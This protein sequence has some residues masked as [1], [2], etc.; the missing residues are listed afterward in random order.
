MGVL[1]VKVDGNW[2]DIPSIGPT[3]PAGLAGATG[4]Q[5]AQG[6][7]G[8]PGPD[9]TPVAHAYATV[10]PDNQTLPTGVPPALN[11]ALG[12]QNGF[13]L[14]GSNK[15]RATSAGTYFVIASFT[16][17]AIAAP[18]TWIQPRVW[19][20][21]ASVVISYNRT[22]Q[23]PGISSATTG[24][25]EGTSQGT[26][27]LQAGD[28][29]CMGCEVSVAR[30]IDARSFINVIGIG[31]TSPS[32]V[33]AWG[34]MPWTTDLGHLITNWPNATTGQMVI[35]D[36]GIVF[37]DG[38]AWKTCRVVGGGMVSPTTDASG[39]ATISHSL[40]YT[41]ATIICTPIAPSTGTIPGAIIVP[42][43]TSTNFQVRVLRHDTGAAFASLQCYFYWIAF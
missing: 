41:P 18:G 3:G 12:A 31:T 9:P 4:P 7:Q 43:C 2:M 29:I 16:V 42:T 32:A 35:G 5:G 19:H 30:A 10:S 13:T 33:A 34:V 21:R 28:D 14:V 25:T 23:H 39:Y 36:T 8:D 6:P 37:W 24:W 22:V 15:L 11:L 26:F 38:A 17:K 27:V 1:R 20:E 40:G